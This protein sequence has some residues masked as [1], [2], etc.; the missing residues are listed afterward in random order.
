MVEHTNPGN[1]LLNTSP[2]LK[3]TYAQPLTLELL[4]EHVPVVKA[5]AAANDRIAELGESYKPTDTAARQEYN[6]LLKQVRAGKKSQE[7]LIVSALPLIKNLTSKEFSR[8]KAWAS[9]VSYEDIL[10]EAIIGFIRGLLSY[11]P[12]QTKNS[13]T[14]YLGQW[15]VV[16]IRRRLE[17]MEHD[18]FIPYEVVERNRKIVAVRS[19]LTSELERE[20]SDEELLDALNDNTQKTNKWG[21]AAS[22]GPSDGSTTKR[23][24]DFTHE[25]LEASKQLTTKLYA[26]QS[27][28]PADAEEEG[29]Y[30]RSS[31]T[32]SAAEP[33]SVSNIEDA[34]VLESK[35]KFFI[36][37][38]TM[39]KIGSKQR[40]IILRFFGMQPYEEPQN[41][42]EIVAETGL[43]SRFVKNVVMSFN[44]Y[45]AQKGGIFHYQIL[46]LD[47]ETV[48]DLEL[49][50]LLPILGEWPTNVNSPVTPPNTLTAAK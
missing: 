8:R 9:R 38:F 41:Y 43:S 20:P 37:V 22:D 1:I 27:N 28:E 48:V 2:L 13:A 50:W 23:K 42:R 4:A 5:G 30:E 31:S 19:R 47:E 15:I 40:D 7:Q 24:A 6:E 35:R 21:R 26:M 29:M 46:Q 36:G 44:Q 32:L 17:V 34:S 45:M 33:A 16:T 10:Q 12:T 14:N 11:K 18:F 3:R 25:H 39:M 49:E